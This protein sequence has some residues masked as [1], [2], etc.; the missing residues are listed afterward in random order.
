MRSTSSGYGNE[1]RERKNSAGGETLLVRQRK[2]NG[3][4]EEGVVSVISTTLLC[5]AIPLCRWK[6]LS[7][8]AALPLFLFPR[9]H[10][11]PMLLAAI[12]SAC[13][14]DSVARGQN[15]LIPSLFLHTYIYRYRAKW[16]VKHEGFC[17]DAV[18]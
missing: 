9:H 10:P 17:P 8:P 12:S 11:S 15:I 7:P 2:I 14:V 18:H 6:H 3:V 1:K 5:P 16:V 4:Y 13:T